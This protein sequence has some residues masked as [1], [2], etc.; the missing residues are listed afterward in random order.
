MRGHA[1]TVPLAFS[2]QQRADIRS[3]TRVVQS[4]AL[5]PGAVAGVCAVAKSYRAWLA[6]FGLPLTF[7]PEVIQ[8]WLVD[9]LREG[10]CA[11]SLDGRLTNLRRYARSVRMPFPAFGT[12][13][14]D[15]IKDTVRACKKIEPTEPKRATIVDLHWLLRVAATLG[16][17]RYADLR[18]IPL[19]KLQLL[20]RAFMCWNNM[21]RG[22]EHRNG[23]R[24][25]DVQ[26]VRT[27]GGQVKTFLLAIAARWSNKKKK[28]CPARTCV[29]PVEREMWSA[30]GVMV[31]Y[32][33]R[34]GFFDDA[35]DHELFPLISGDYHVDMGR[36]TTDETFV[37]GFIRQ[38]KTAGM[39]AAA[40]KKVSNHSFRAGGAT[41]MSVG[42]LDEATIAVQGGWTS[43]ALRVYIR[44][45]AHHTM[46]RSIAMLAA[47]YTVLQTNDCNTGL[48]TSELGAP[49][50]GVSR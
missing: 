40:L 8:D 46:A 38:L 13:D 7:R 15:D 2:N 30:G 16:V 20:A 36:T 5:E 12:Y 14:W 37:R 1:A 28:H 4:L 34:M 23:L 32:A 33:E 47:T 42:G 44:P 45:Q 18:R 10:S 26:V 21:M 25:A 39:S 50:V 41:D 29:M 22:V 49:L 17:A 19:R 3:A 31:I 11:R 9:Y 35:P 43:R 6:A 24:L 27:A 48:M